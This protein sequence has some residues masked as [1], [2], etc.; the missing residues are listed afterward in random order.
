MVYNKA[1]N[2]FTSVDLQV[3]EEFINRFIFT[4]TL[5][6]NVC[7]KDYENIISTFISLVFN[8]FEVC[9]F[10]FFLKLYSYSI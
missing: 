10:G 8:H 9:I 1:G 3:K 6:C 7:G 4:I 5:G 2:V